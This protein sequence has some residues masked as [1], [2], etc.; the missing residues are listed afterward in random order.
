MGLC[1]DCSG[2]KISK[3]E[4]LAILDTDQHD[5][6]PMS[7]IRRSLQYE[8]WTSVGTCIQ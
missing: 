3:S 4:E 6:R 7:K 5:L 2:C 1:D 8:Q